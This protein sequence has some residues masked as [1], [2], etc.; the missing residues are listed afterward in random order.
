MKAALLLLGF[1]C[2]GITVSGQT[3]TSQVID[4]KTGQPVAYVNIGIVGKNIGTVSDE[5]GKFQLSISEA[6]DNDTLKFSM[7][8]YVTKANVV[9]NVRR[10]GLPASIKMDQRQIQ[11]QE[12]IVSG[13][14]AEQIILG[15]AKKHCYPIPLYKGASSN[16]T[17]PQKGSRH[18][19]GTRLSNTQAIRLDSIQ[20]NFA[21][22]QPDSLA[23]RLNIYTIENETISNILEEPIYIAL[24]KEETMNF[25]IINLTK[26]QIEVNTDFLV[27]IENYRNMPDGSTKL[28]AN[29]KAKGRVFPTYYRNSSQSNWV[30]LQT[31]KSKD[32][33]LSIIVFAN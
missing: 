18:E 20:I 12:V 6:S 13:E 24:S 15:L 21:Y 19:I 1:I 11:L 31:K 22:V 27:T 25:P 14:S 10:S 7:I 26:Y 3:I 2:F 33:G 29:F 9:A 8:S 23:F 4:S 30:K 17:F 16:F 5:D 32:I 28:L